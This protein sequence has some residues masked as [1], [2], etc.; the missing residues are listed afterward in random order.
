MM[1]Q[2][3]AWVLVTIPAALLL[4]SA[5]QVGNSQV[6]PS[7]SAGQDTMVDTTETDSLRLVNGT[8][9]TLLYQAFHPKSARPLRR[10]IE[11]DLSNPQAEVVQRGE[12]AVLWA[13]DALDTY[14]GYTLHLYR[15]GAADNDGMATAQL[16]RSI[17]LTRDRLVELQQEECR[18]EISEL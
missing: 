9:G 1:Q 14:E 8:E 15:V 4:V 12:S 6:R 2:L 7:S 11:V 13:C 18:L 10:Q 16:S 3:G 17:D 5:C